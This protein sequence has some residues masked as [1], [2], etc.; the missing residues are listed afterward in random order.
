M[1]QDFEA[2]TPNLLARTIETVEG[3]GII[4]ILL[5]SVNSLKQLYTLSMDVHERYRTE[6]HK[7]VAGRFNERYARLKFR[8]IFAVKTH[9]LFFR[10]L[11]S[12]S[13]NSRCLVVDDQLAVLPITAKALDIEPVDKQNLKN[14]DE[15]ELNEVKE[16]LRD[17]Q[18]IGAL[19]NCCKTVD[20]VSRFGI[21]SMLVAYSLEYS[22]LSILIFSGQSGVE[23]HRCYFGE[24][25][26]IYGL[27][28]C[29]QRSR[30]VGGFRISCC[31]RCGFR[32]LEYF[33]N[34][35]FS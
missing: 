8:E 15:G 23:V 32:L 2:L 18:P 30:K 13:S 9:G 12:L 20:Q 5:R 25:I 16:S 28:D 1:F 22:N 17:T 31:R 3:G 27:F 21:L 24:N 10:F 33:R 35:S 7:D 6:A 4:V 26:T 34:F 29:L 19:V 11:L 14:D